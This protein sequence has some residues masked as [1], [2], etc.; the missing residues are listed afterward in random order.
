MNTALKLYADIDKALIARL[1]T[2][3]AAGAYSAGYRVMDLAMIP[4]NAW[5]TATTA[6]FFKAGQ[7]GLGDALKY[8][9]RIV[10]LPA[11]YAVVVGFALY[12]SADMLP[13]VLGRSYGAAVDVL[14]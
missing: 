5:L 4:M 1:V 2:L 10:P 7:S 14:K 3:E 13:H 8:G 9:W 6:R 11:V 12:A